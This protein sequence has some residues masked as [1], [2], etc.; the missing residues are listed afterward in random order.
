MSRISSPA[1][2]KTGSLGVPTVLHELSVGKKVQP[3][4]VK[5]PPLVVK[6]IR[7]HGGADFIRR[8]LRHE[9][10]SRGNVENE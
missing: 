8:A 5:L 1:K 10:L 6:Y 2:L 3:Y 9:L 4:T 7:E